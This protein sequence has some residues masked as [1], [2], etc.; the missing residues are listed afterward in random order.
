MLGI[1]SL[2]SLLVGLV[3]EVTG[4]KGAFPPVLAPLGGKR[5][6]SLGW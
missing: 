3:D 2:P 1:F 6:F 4:S 5:G